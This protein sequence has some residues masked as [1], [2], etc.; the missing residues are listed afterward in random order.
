MLSQ[1]ELTMYNKINKIL[2]N[3]LDIE[4]LKSN[5]F[6]G[7]PF[8]HVIIDN[9]FD[10]DFALEVVK[11]LPDYNSNYFDAKYDNMIEKKKTIQNWSM[12]P[13]NVYKAFNLLMGQYFTLLLREV[14]NQPWLTPDI[15][16]HGGGIHMH[17][18]GDYLN[19]H[20]DYEIHPKLDMKR[21]L[22][23]IIYMEPS[24]QPEWGGNLELWSHDPETNRPKELV[25]SITPKFNRAVI[26]DTTQNSWHGVTGG[27]FSPKGIYRKSLAAYYLIPATDEE[28]NA[29]LRKR[30]LFAPRVDQIDNPEVEEFIKNR[31]EM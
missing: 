13:P 28:L 23:I 16:L 17:Q 31:S 10:E 26:F 12:F 18:A 29:S 7:K 15:G 24:W 6:E 27:I 14:T 4:E 2:V 20:Y 25:S 11:E 5:F 19:T 1:S 3:G 22:N 21:K 8:N 9:F 30:A